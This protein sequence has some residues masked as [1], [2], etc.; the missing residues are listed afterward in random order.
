MHT[1]HFGRALLAIGLIALWLSGGAAVASDRDQP[2]HIEADSVELDEEQAISLYV[3]NVVVEQGGTRI[4]ADW[5]LV[6]HRPNHEPEQITAIGDPAKYRQK[7][8]GETKESRAQALRMEYDVI[9][10]EVTLIERAVLF[11]GQD[12]FSSDRIIYDRANA[13]VKAGGSAAGSE[14]VKIT[15]TP[16]AQ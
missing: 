15:I 11:Q 6:R 9:N 13:R 14:R 4:Q 7:A 16:E 3:G 2:I 10:D 5:V 1:T 12:R 8:E